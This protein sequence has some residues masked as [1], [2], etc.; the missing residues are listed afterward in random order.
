VSSYEDKNNE[1]YI[2]PIKFMG[3]L[4]Q[5]KKRILWALKKVPG[6]KVIKDEQNYVYAEVTS[7]VFK[8][9]DD[10]EFVLNPEDKVIHVKSASRTGRSD[11]GVNRK[12]V[13]QVRFEFVQGV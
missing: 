9:V 7:A 2:K 3:D 11:W 5:S 10:I 6:V 4:E 1:H 12:R 13:E 8:F